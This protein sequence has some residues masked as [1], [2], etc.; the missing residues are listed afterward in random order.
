MSSTTLRYLSWNLFWM[1]TLQWQG[2]SAEG[3][4]GRK[5][6]LHLH[7]VRSK[8]VHCASNPSTRYILFPL[9]IVLQTFGIFNRTIKTMRR[10]TRPYYKKSLQKH[11]S[12][13][14]LPNYECRVSDAVPYL[15][16]I[17]GFDIKGFE[18]D[19]VSWIRIWFGHEGMI[20]RV[21]WTR[22][23]YF[24]LSQV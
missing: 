8:T 21:K 11:A 4:R 17:L 9:E 15:Q 12:G 13:G 10:E 23:L 19:C 3:W 6:W 5:I 2:D 16:T 1:G 24:S 14:K 22:D 20:V 7:F 18:A